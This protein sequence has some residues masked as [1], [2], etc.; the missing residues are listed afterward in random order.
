M[1]VDER[2]M[3]DLHTVPLIVVLPVCLAWGGV[4]GVAHL[5]GLRI[6]A[7]LLV[8]GERPLLALA[9]TLGRFVLLGAGLY[10]A[11]LAG[12]LALLAAFAGVLCAKALVLRGTG[13]DP[14]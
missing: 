12:A 14:A 4:L 1:E 8:R 5:R 3:I 11:A 10:V 6:T 2:T 9:L 7:D 13:G